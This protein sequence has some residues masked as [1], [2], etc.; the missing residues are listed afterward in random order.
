MGTLY[1][2]L[3]EYQIGNDS[4]FCIRPNQAHRF[5]LSADMEGFVFSFTD[6]FF[7][8]AEQEFDCSSQISLLQIFSQ[9]LHIRIASDAEPAIKEIAVLMIKEYENQFALGI[10]LLKRYFRIFL[11]YLSRQTDETSKAAI[12]SRESGLLNAFMEMLEHNFK[13]KKMVADYAGKLCVTPNYLNRVIKK[14]TGFPARHH[15]KQRVLLEAKRLGR[16]SNAGMKQ[17]AYSLGFS[18]S[19]H[20]SKFFKSGSG[21]NFSEFKNFKDA[22][23]RPVSFQRA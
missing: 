16:Y 19:A 7:N 12:Q 9:S 23:S 3:R 21:T 20:F 14:N 8:T 5:N 22:D 11:I 13:E 1:S 10:E 17:I 2:D 4:I 15:I 6:S 18:D